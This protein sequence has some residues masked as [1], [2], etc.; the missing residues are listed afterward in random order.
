MFFIINY[1]NRNATLKEPFTCKY[2]NISPV[3]INEG[4][5]ALAL[6]APANITYEI[7][8]FT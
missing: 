1:L 2:N 7:I 4:I 8:L 5:A 3:E 6:I